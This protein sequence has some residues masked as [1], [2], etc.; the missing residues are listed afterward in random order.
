MTPMPLADAS[1][2]RQNG[3][4]PSRQRWIRWRTKWEARI[5]PEQSIVRVEDIE[6]CVQQNKERKC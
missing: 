3:I 1:V 4:R 2:I 6:K 5:D